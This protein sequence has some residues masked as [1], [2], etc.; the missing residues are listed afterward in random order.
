MKVFLID[1]NALIYRIYH[2][3]PRLEDKE[4]RPTNALYGLSNILLKLLKENSIDYIFA[5]YD[6]PEPTIRHQVFKE[7]KITRPKITDDLKIQIPLSKKIFFAFNIPVI[8]KIGYEA[9]DLIA[10]LKEKFSES[11]DEI[12]I[13]TG[14]LDTL[15]LVDQKTKILT[16]Q[17]G[18][19]Q[20]KIYDE[21]EVKN[22]F[23]ILPSQIPDYKALVGDASDN[24][25]G[26]S[27]IGP[28][29]ASALLQRY[30]N[31]EN[32][33]ELAE[34][35]LLEKSL[36]EK[37][38]NNKEKLLFYKDLVTLRKDIPI[39]ESFEKYQGYKIEN[40]ISVFQEFGF[41]SLIQRL[42][43][44]EIK[45]TTS[46][47][48]FTKVES[49]TKEEKI[50]DLKNIKVPFYFYLDKE[51]IKINDGDSEIKILPKNLIKE[52][53]QI[54][55]EKFVFDLK[56][57]LKDLIK[58]DFYFDKK[59]NFG[60][61]YDVKIISWLLNIK[62]DNPNDVSLEQ[63]FNYLKKLKEFN[64]DKIYFELELPLVS[65]LARMEIYG[66]KINLEHLEKFK[67]QLKE[68]TNELLQEIQNL[69][70][71]KFNPNSPK[72]LRIVLFQKLKLPT[73]GLSKTSKGEISTQE[74][75]LL[76]IVHLHPIVDK[77]LEYRKLNKLLT[78][79][80]DSLLKNFNLKT[81]RIYTIF[82][83]T[84][85]ST[86][87]IVSENPNLQ[88]LPITGE[89]AQILRKAFVA[90]N[91]YV[92]IS[93]D[94]SQLELRLLAHL[95]KDENL[96]AVFNQNLDIHSESAKLIFGKDDS[97]SRRKAKIVNFGIVYGI[98]AK[99]LSQR[100][101]I[102]VSSAQ[103]L[104][105]RFFY[106]YPQVKKLKEDLIE[107]AKTYGYVETLFGRKRF[108]PEIFSQSYREKTLAERI[109]INTPI[110]GLG[111][112]ILKKA[113]IGI[114]DEF[115]K[116]KINGYLVLTIHDEIIVEVE[117]SKKEEVKSII[118]EK[119]ETSFKLDIPLEVKIKEGKN[120]AELI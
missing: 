89:L 47:G 84:S 44:E 87:R 103:K 82:D 116:R 60:N 76:K 23:G 73:K 71:I 83:Q 40:L 19:S 6:R 61:I 52:I 14:D 7:Y 25:P 36:R 1:A 93:G 120:L 114:D 107:F 10:T 54:E 58:E 24:I 81:S 65:I 101:G 45:K 80:T 22:R 43:G 77:I 31:L 119:M 34:K 75:D 63:I 12:I 30:Q 41:R 95:S 79:Y 32:L 117:E 27:G 15:Q 68:K 21:K 29:T 112:D 53:F 42:Q 110:Q 92:F 49:K 100:L 16:M 50:V 88:N 78:T 64:L 108:V 67:Q 99:G 111:A 2:A 8:E 38:L 11:A 104:I 74:K 96:T 57:I 51:N 66:I 98:S 85:A 46:L 59:V 48:L 4:G 18:I 55:G 105:D 91:G 17:K 118:K 28:K 37:I 115:Y 33:I 13:L 56:E 97:E 35:G 70:G 86:G 20:T 102:P 26:I 109:I 72:D 3:L 9:D 69:A 90:E 5:L 113:M 62:I 106:F 94:Y 39:T